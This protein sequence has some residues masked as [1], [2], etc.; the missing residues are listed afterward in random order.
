MSSGGNDTIEESGNEKSHEDQNP[1][2][3]SPPKLAGIVPQDGTNDS[4]KGS[5][6]KDPSLPSI[7]LESDNNSYDSEN[8]KNLHDQIKFNEASLAQD[9]DKHAIEWKKN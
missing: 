8:L 5:G 6:E 4:G 2:P 1:P 9:P 3:P 7:H